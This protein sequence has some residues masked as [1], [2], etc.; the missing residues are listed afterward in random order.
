MRDYTIGGKRS[1]IA[2]QLTKTELQASRL[3][4]WDAARRKDPGETGVVPRALAETDRAIVHALSR[5]GR[6]PFQSIADDLEISE[7]Q[8]RTRVNDMISSGVMSWGGMAR[9]WSCRTLGP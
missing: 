7:S 3:L 4:L 1:K 2:K 6:A 9:V 8:V 5:D